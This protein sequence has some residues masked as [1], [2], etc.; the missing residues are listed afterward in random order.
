MEDLTR[1]IRNLSIEKSQK[2]VFMTT[3]AEIITK[4][5]TVPS[6][7]VIEPCV[8]NGDLLRLVGDQKVTTYDIRDMSEKKHPNF[9][10]K[11]TIK[12][13]PSYSGKFVLANP[14]YLAR[15]KADDKELFDLYDENDLYK[16]FIRTLIAD[17]PNGGILIIPL[18]F[19]CSVRKSDAELRKSF[20]SKFNITKFNL[21]KNQIF[22]DTTYTICSFQFEKTAEPSNSFNISIMDGETK[23]P[24][25]DE[26][27]TPPANEIKISLSD[28]NNWTIGGE[29]FKMTNS[30]FSRATKKASANT[31]LNVHCIDNKKLIHMEYAEPGADL[32]VDETK[33]LSSRSFMTLISPTELT[34]EQQK[35]LC[36]KWNSY[37]TEQRSKYHSLFLPNY[38]DKY[39]KRIPFDLVYKIATRVSSPKK[40]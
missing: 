19:W 23:T 40:S 17:P 14:P 32:Y 37:L 12:H 31:R 39:R 29:L 16:C 30:G 9:E 10:I 36:S 21:F 11:D 24:P 22:E 6:I 13:P 26:I 38:R 3:N 20:I 8:G 27:K 2:G 35:L 33:N 15:N 25:A 7:H 34:A 18:N 1:T 4:G 28:K 5:M